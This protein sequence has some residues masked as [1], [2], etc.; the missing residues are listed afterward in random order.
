MSPWGEHPS[1]DSRGKSLRD[2]G[3]KGVARGARETRKHRVLVYKQERTAWRTGEHWPM[4]ED[5]RLS[6]GDS[7]MSYKKQF[8]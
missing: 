2:R 3:G 7:L 4:Q 8:W 6:V 5:N 1:R